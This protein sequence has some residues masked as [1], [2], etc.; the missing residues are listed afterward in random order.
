LRDFDIHIRGEIAW[1]TVIN[2]NIWVA[3]NEQA[4]TLLAQSEF[5]ETGNASDPNQRE[6]RSSY[7]ESEVLLKTPNGW[8]IVLGHTSLVPGPKK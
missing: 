7:V 1:I 2:D 4:R 3:D 5:E 6:W 8:K